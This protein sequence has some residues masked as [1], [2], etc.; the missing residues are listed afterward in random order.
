MRIGTGLLAAVFAVAVA[1][2]QWLKYLVETRLELQEKVDVLPFLA[3]Y[4]TYN[5][6]IAFSMLSWF[7]DKG[8]IVVTL[9]VAAFIL[10]LAWRSDPAQVF[11]RLG[12]TLILGGAI[13][14]L[15]DRAVYG[16]V[17]D[18]VLFHTP[19]WSFAV[20]NLA[21]VFI[22]IGAGLVILEEFLIWRRGRSAAPDA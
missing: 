6:G 2:D 7:G 22:T 3:L 14:N 5:T 8:L 16:H 11:A 13:G 4:R 10:Y 15:I 20:F 12:F 17:V 9:A 19:V 18:Y 1:L 21:D